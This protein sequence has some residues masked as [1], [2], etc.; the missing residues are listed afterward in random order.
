METVDIRV[1]TGKYKII[2]W[3]KNLKVHFK[4]F[5][6]VIARDI[7]SILYF[8]KKVLIN[9]LNHVQSYSSLFSQV[10]HLPIIISG[11]CIKHLLNI[12]AIP[13]STS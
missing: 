11:I 9:N 5:K 4:K 13:N 3:A 8:C 6:K 10:D 12:A 7:L 1:A 2:N